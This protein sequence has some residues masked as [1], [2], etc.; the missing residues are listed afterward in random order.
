[1]SLVR[2]LV[3]AVRQTIRDHRAPKWVAEPVRRVANYVVALTVVA[4]AALAL[5]TSQANLVP[6]KYRV[7]FLAFVASATVVTATVAKVAGEV[8]RSKVFA[9]ATVDRIVQGAKADGFKAALR[10]LGAQAEP[11]GPGSFP[12]KP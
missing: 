8:A 3:K 7:E 2:K 9:P 12:G 4:G 5:A 10:D 11:K 6:E 1:V